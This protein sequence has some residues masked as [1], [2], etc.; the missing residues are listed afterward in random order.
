MG[1]YLGGAFAP[2]LQPPLAAKLYVGCEDVL[3]KGKNGTDNLYHHAKFGQTFCTA[4]GEKVR[5]FFICSSHFGMT[6]IVN[7]DSRSTLSL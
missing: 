7:T 6:K 4:G 2:N 5:R 1:V 3:Y